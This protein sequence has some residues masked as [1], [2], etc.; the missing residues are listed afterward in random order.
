MTTDE[1]SIEVDQFDMDRSDS[2]LAH[3][4]FRKAARRDEQPDL[5]V[6]AYDA[7]ERSDMPRPSL[8]PL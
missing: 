6:T 7:S 1:T 3:G 4:L 8:G 5:A 2:G